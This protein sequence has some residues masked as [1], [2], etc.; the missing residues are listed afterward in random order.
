M[1]SRHL[2]ASRHPLSVAAASLLV[3][4]LTACSKPAEP[5]APIRAV[6]TV[7]LKD[8]GG[9]IDREFSS[10]V[11]ARTETR[12]SFRVAGKVTQRFAEL[13]Q[14]VKAG[15]TLAQLD[16][17]DLRL[18]QDA[19]RAGLTAAQVQVAQAQADFKRYQDLRA[20]GFISQAELERHQTHLRAAEASMAQARA[21]LGVQGNQAAYGTLS[22]TASGI[23]TAVT[24]EPGQVV[25]PGEPVLTLAHD[26]ARDVVFSV[27]EDMGAAVRP[28]VGKASAIKVRRWGTEKW[29]PATIR[30]MAAAADPNSRTLLVKADVG[31]HPDFTLGQ[32]ATVALSVAPRVRDGVHV[33]LH[34]LVEHQGRSSVWLLDPASMTVKQ[35]DVVTS[36]VNGNMMHVAA[37]L[38][39]GQEVVTAGVH[40][41]MPGQKVRR[42][43]EPGAVAAAPAGTSLPAAK[44]AP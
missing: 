32:T 30:E 17:T 38:K 3:L 40:V 29:V 14:T 20:Q 11:K 16:A 24:V 2:P 10:E 6:R 33:P 9:L 4:A 34:A 19:A 35:Q 21:Q 13:G 8:A 23:I 28:L 5:E 18:T 37:G 22:A 12:L 31:P 27:P 25:A 36:E 39:P 15:Q 42:L 43:V 41:L 26:G 44:A 1:N 7:V